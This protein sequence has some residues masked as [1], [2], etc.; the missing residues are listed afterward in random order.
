LKIKGERKMKIVGTEQQERIW[1]E[2]VESTDHLVVDAKAGTG[3]TFTIVEGANRIPNVS[4]LF[5]AFNKSIA[6]EIGTK[7]PMDCEAK[8]F[9]SLGMGALKRHNSKAKMDFKKDDNIVKAVMGKNFK[10][11]QGLKKLISLLKSSMIEWDDK[12]GI[13]NLIDE[14]SIEFDG[15]REKNNAILKLPQIKNLSLDVSIFNFDDMIWLP[16]VLELPVKHYDVVFVDEAQDFNESQRRLILKACNG[17]RMII[18]GDP[19]QAIYG[20]RGADS[21]S[22]SIFKDSLKFSSREIKEFPLTVSW[23]CPTAVVQEANRFVPDFEAADNAEEG[24]V[25]TNVDFVPKV[26]DMVLC[27]VNAPLVSHCFSLITAGIPAYVLGRDIGQSLNALV[28]KVTQDVSM[29]IAS[30]KEAL[31]K[32]VDVQVRMLMEQEKEKFAHNLQDRRDCLFALMANTQTVKGLMDN[33]KTIFDDGKRAGVVFSTIHK[34]KGLESNTVWILKPDLMPHPMAKS[35]ADREQEMNLCYVAITR[36]K[37]VLN[38]CGRRV[39]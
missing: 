29:D 27:R 26:G 37:K 16:V 30:F 20:F 18:V 36:A 8:T 2:M 10:S 3:K 24:E 4:K 13:E 19:K 5:L 31:V 38:Y 6:T 17:G 14:Y 28:K 9:H 33:I 39:G 12:A 22:M 7:L 15:I 35:K 25:N 32:Y 21:R 23:R 1:K 34:A 11:K